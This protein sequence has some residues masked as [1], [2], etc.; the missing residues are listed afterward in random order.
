MKNNKLIEKGILANYQIDGVVG[1]IFL[2]RI[3]RDNVTTKILK[4]VDRKNSENKRTEQF[5]A[6]YEANKGRT[7]MLRFYLSNQYEAKNGNWY[8][9]DAIV[10]E[11][12]IEGE[13]D[14]PQAPKRQSDTPAHPAPESEQQQ[15]SVQQSDNAPI[16]MNDDDYL[17]F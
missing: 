1:M 11:E 16:D 5:Q 12:M 14:A 2:E 3:Y 7:V 6:F 17:P 8:G 4:V 10:V 15:E 9:S 13:A